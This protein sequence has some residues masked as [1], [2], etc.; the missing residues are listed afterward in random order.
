MSNSAGLE[1]CVRSPVWIRKS[2]AAGSGID[3][4]HGSL[5]RGR[6]VGVR[7]LVEADVAVADL[8]EGEIGLRGWLHRF[9]E[10]ARGRHAAGK[11]PDEAGAGPGHALQKSAAV[12]AVGARWLRFVLLRF[13][14]AY[15]LIRS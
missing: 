8:H 13:E 12:D 1:E 10:D 9:A 14:S 4:P 15:L 5:Q 2:G 7:R 11:G 3:P 6:H